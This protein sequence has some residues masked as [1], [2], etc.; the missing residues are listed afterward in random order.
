MATSDYQRAGCPLIQYL[1]WWAPPGS[2]SKWMTWNWAT[3]R[4]DK[5][6]KP[7]IKR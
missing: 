1:M 5:L 2:S 7:E 4:W 6:D 3:G